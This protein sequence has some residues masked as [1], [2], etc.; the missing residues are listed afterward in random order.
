[1]T[2]GEDVAAAL[3]ELRS[4]AESM[5]TSACVITGPGEKTWN[6]TTGTYDNPAVTIYTGPCR[7]AFRSTV[8]REAEAVGQLLTEQEPTL[9]L[10][11]DGSEGVSTDHVV[12]ITAN[13]LDAALVGMRLRVAG[14]H[15][16]TYATARRLALEV[17]S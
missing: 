17:V 11:V 9:Y 4:A 14:I 12:T 2:L 3:P 16:Q 7:I 8:R 15:A 13:P 10:P 5:M 6:N 1:M